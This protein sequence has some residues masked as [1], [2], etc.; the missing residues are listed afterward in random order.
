MPLLLTSS[1]G[2]H[3]RSP[4]QGVLAAGRTGRRPDTF[5]EHAI[6]KRLPGTCTSESDS[7]NWSIRASGRLT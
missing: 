3:E 6:S 5:L 1:E 2:A 7:T 4:M